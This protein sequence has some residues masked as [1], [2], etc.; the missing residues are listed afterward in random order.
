MCKEPHPCGC[1]KLEPI[2]WAIVEALREMQ[3][4]ILSAQL[5]ASLAPMW[6]V[7]NGV[8]TSAFQRDK[9]SAY[10]CGTNVIRIDVKVASK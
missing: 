2:E 8:S 4:R 1:P 10:S 6:L 9:V 3:A 7:V 5:Q